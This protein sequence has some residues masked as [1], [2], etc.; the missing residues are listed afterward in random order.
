M[1]GRANFSECEIMLLL[2]LFVL[3]PYFWSVLLSDSFSIATTFNPFDIKDMT[4][5]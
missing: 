5:L 4:V 2:N 3:Q 1:L